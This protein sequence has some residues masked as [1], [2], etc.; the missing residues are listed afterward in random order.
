MIWVIAIKKINRLL[1]S[2]PE[3]RR[4]SE[5]KLRRAFPITIPVDVRSILQIFTRMIFYTKRHKLP[6]AREAV[7][8]R[9]IWAGLC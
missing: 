4:V 3:S 7:V 5:R 9:L 1:L 8:L 2:A 6:P